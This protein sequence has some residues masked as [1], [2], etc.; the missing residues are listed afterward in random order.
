MTDRDIDR[1]KIIQGLKACSRTMHIKLCND[2]PYEDD[3]EEDEE[4]NYEGSCVFCLTGDALTLIEEQEKLL[5]NED[6]I[7][8]Q[9]RSDGSFEPSWYYCCGNCDGPIDKPDKYCRHCGK[10]VEWYLTDH[11]F[12][13]YN[14]K[15]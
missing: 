10:K 9:I 12:E 11:L 6:P 4:G 1:D 13:S 5:K 7:A 2:C 15:K 14:E 8:P 3:E